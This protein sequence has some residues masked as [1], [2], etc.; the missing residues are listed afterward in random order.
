MSEPAAP[1][2]YSQYKDR[3][4]GL[5]VFGV[6]ELMMGAFF[7]LMVLLMLVNTLIM[8]NMRIEVAGM[9]MPWRNMIPSIMFYAFLTAWFVILGTGSIRTRRWA[10]ALW[11]ASSWLLLVSG[12]TG[13]IGMA[14][15]MPSMATQ[16]MGSAAL[17]PESTGFLPAALIAIF[18]V[19]L[20]F[21]VIVPGIFIWFYGSKHVKATCEYL[22]PHVRWTDKCPVPV[23]AMVLATG[24][25][26]VILPM[27][28]GYNWAVPFFGVVLSGWAGAGIT[29]FAM[30]LLTY[31]AWG[32]Y[33]LDMK[34]WWLAI[35]SVALLLTSVLLTFSRVELIGYYEAMDFPPEQLELL[36]D[37]M[38]PSSSMFVLCAIWVVPFTV[39]F[40]YIRRYFV[41]GRQDG[42]GNAPEA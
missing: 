36:R 21:Y 40:W 9:A 38:I 11:L 15:I 2:D 42:R 32:A 1:V 25:Y 10:R 33:R 6:I 23:L 12:V 24:G 20:F 17:P 30:A 14:F 19:A 31:I 37:F 28:G 34:A 3:K 13:M 26:V 35:I 27:M 5:I 39:Y 29:F 16:F 41:A 8:R 4:A 7:A 18:V 22:D